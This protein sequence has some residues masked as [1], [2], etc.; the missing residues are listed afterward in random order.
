MFVAARR[1]L[2]TV[3]VVVPC[4]NYGHY[5]TT[6]VRSVLSQQGVEVRLLIIDDC[7]SDGTAEIGRQLAI[8]VDHHPQ[9]RG[10]R[11]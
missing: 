5:L 6:C 11:R 8:A 10:I 9:I 2:S 4:Y 1:P 7:S 3:D